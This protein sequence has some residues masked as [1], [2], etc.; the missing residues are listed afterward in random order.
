MPWSNTDKSLIA[1]YILWKRWGGFAD[2]TKN[3]VL[4]GILSTWFW[5]QQRKVYSCTDR[6]LYVDLVQIF[7]QDSGKN[8]SFF[9]IV[10]VWIPIKII[11]GIN[12]QD[13]LNW[14]VLLQILEHSYRHLTSQEVPLQ[15]HVPRGSRCQGRDV[16]VAG[17]AQFCPKPNSLAQC[18][19]NPCIRFDL[20]HIFLSYLTHISI[21]FK[22]PI[23]LSTKKMP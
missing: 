6:L 4:R 12:L 16:D 8:C 13:Q 10:F 22:I 19:W 9:K 18:L 23:L 7:L 15:C 1:I 5:Y 17:W 3:S 11:S 21:N 14:L 2:W 20:W